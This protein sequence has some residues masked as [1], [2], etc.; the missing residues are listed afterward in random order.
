[1]VTSNEKVVYTVDDIMEILSVKRTTVH[2][3]IKEGELKAVKIGRM[4]R[5]PKE[6][7][8]EFMRKNIIDKKR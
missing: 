3:W 8:D 6:F 4:L 5:I 7:Y 2:K 1:M